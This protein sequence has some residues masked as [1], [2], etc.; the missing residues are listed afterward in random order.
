VLVNA[1]FRRRLLDERDIEDL[2]LY[3]LSKTAADSL[4]DKASPRF[5]RPLSWNGLELHEVDRDS[6][7]FTRVTS[8]KISP[9]KLARLARQ[10]QQNSEVFVLDTNNGEVHCKKGRLVR[11]SGMRDPKVVVTLQTTAEQQ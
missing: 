11:V 2:R 4:Q 3:Q 1:A 6:S 5:W 8:T 10:G 9:A 7:G